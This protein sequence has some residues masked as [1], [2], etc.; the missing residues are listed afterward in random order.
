MKKFAYLE[1]ET[2]DAASAVLAD[3]LLTQCPNVR[4]LATSRQALGVA[5]EQIYQVPGLSFPS[6][7][8][9]ETLDDY[10]A[11]RLFRHRAR[12]A[13]PEFEI[14][15]ADA[16]AIGFD[17]QE[18]YRELEKPVGERALRAE[19]VASCYDEA[20]ACYDAWLDRENRTPY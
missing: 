7:G 18:F 16:E 10:E 12:Q 4:F 2:F 17:D 19:Q 15:A 20:R 6:N 14:A 1:A 8:A 9:F 13:R 3:R 11:V 5:G